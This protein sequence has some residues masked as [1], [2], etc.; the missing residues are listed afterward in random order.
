MTSAT[1][2]GA[3]ELAAL[4][5]SKVCHDLVNPVGAIN[6]GLEVLGD[7]SNADMHEFAMELVTKSVGQASNKLKVARMAYGAGASAGSEIDL[8][9]AGEVARGVIESERTKLTWNAG[10]GGLAKDRAKLLLNLLTIA[11]TI[12][13]RG[14]EITVDVDGAAGTFTVAAKGTNAKIPAGVAEIVAGAIP[15]TGV[16]AQTIQPYYT[17]LIAADAGLSVAFDMGE[18]RCVIA[19]TVA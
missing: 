12:I 11:N 15:E 9:E 19:A 6:N 16:D 17:R 3:M 1:A 7:K 4:L 14:G 5:T 18:E 8:G 13:P 10:P 2:P